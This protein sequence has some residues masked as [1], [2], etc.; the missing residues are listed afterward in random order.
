LLDTNIMENNTAKHFALQLGSLASLYLSL[1]FL[2]VLLFG[3]IN[4]AFPDA[5]DG[6]WDIER[7]SSGIR[8]AFAMVI[9]FFPTYLT[10][11]RLVNNNRRQETGGQYLS[12]TKWLIYLSL[13]VGGAVLLGDLVAVII[14]FLE[15]EITTRFIL[16]TLVVLVIIGCAFV[17]Y[18]KDAK[19]YWVEN[20]KKS[21]VFG[22]IA[23]LVVA[24]S[25]VIGFIYTEKPSEVRERKLDDQQI[26]DL[27][28]IQ[29]YIE[30]YY[31]V[32]NA[33]PSTLN[34]LY[35]GLP[36]PAA[37]EG[38]ADYEYLVGDETS[39]A[40]CA[41]FVEE[42]LQNAASRYPYTAYEKN[43]NWDHPSGYWCFE[44]AVEAKLTIE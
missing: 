30:D 22:M 42:S 11:T 34:E 23:S 7:A 40:L 17:Y 25:L 37:P 19:G 8:V 39:Y 43:Y 32:N 44:R 27:Q 33:L 5:T 10:L 3:V 2:L 14:T 18:L 1:S 20:E 21:T 41:T 15:G 9:V 29:F 12:L 16:K 31:R 24:A 35:G 6:P 4:L 26:S 13:L 36:I 28:D 38:R